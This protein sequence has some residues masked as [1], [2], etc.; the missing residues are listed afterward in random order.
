MS[1]LNHDE[2]ANG[3]FEEAVNSEDDGRRIVLLKRAVSL[4]PEF[5]D[6]H[7]ELGKSYLHLGEVEEAER[8]LRAAIEL[9]DNGWAH[10]YLGNLFYG[11]QDWDAA[12]R[13]FQAA[14]KTLP[15]LN[16][17]LWCAGDIYR[18]AGDLD[19]SERYYRKAVEVEPSDAAALARLGR[20]L[21]E[22][23]NRADGAAYI[24]RALEEDATCKVALKWKRRY[25][26]DEEGTRTAA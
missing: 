15:A 13:E 22:R 23:G 25:K 8:A 7:M 3:Y 12:L 11:E 14:G 20:L 10:L 5:S 26:V 24:K 16:V 18:E 6:A 9:D 21:M 4:N 2:R 1:S 19:E 17:P